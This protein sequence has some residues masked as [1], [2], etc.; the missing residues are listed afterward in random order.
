[1]SGNAVRP[2]ADPLRDMITSI[3]KHASS[4]FLHS[5]ISRLD[6]FT[7]AP[8][9]WL[10]DLGDVTFLALLVDGGGLQK[11]MKGS[12]T[13]SCCVFPGNIAWVRAALSSTVTDPEP[14]VSLSFA[15]FS[16]LHG[17][18][19]GY[20]QVATLVSDVRVCVFIFMP[21]ELPVGFAWCWHSRAA[22]HT[23]IRIFMKCMHCLTIR[24][25]IL[26]ALKRAQAN[27]K[28]VQKDLDKLHQ[29]RNVKK[30]HL[31]P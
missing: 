15:F 20:C 24:D 31:R 26:F 30:F 16:W 27:T 2:Y 10:A 18:C 22:Y 21:L 28:A 17:F 23:K 4:C 3:Y 12:Y 19:I 8:S 14:H 7:K 1:M 6:L 11:P 5:L 29:T 13:H 9:D 25:F